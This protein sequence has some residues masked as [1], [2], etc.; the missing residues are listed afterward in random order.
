MPDYIK[1]LGGTLREVL[2]NYINIVIAVSFVAVT[3][4]G[5]QGDLAMLMFCIPSGMGRALGI[6]N[7]VYY[8]A[9]GRWR[10]FMLT[11][12]S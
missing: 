1:R 9:K 8:R 12:L 10:D 7:G 5:I 2:L 11:V 3:V 4:R 6:I